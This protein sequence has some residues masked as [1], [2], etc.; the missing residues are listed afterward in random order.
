MGIQLYT[1]VERMRGEKG[2]E[3]IKK[4]KER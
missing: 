1:D 3:G 2:R 4:E